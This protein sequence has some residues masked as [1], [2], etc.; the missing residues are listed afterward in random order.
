MPLTPTEL[1]NVV[2]TEK[3]RLVKISIHTGDPGTTGADEVSGGSYARG[4]LTFAS[5]AAGG[6]ASANQV[7]INVPAGGPYTH[8][9]V[10]DSAGTTFEGG[11]PLSSSETFGADGQIKVTV[12]LA[13]TAS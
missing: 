11:N 12:T 1:N 9:G 13:G 7:T 6:S 3:A 8:F 10:W 2:D 5:G 4:T